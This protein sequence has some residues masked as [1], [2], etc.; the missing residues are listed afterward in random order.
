MIGKLFLPLLASHAA[1]AAAQPAS[2]PQ[3]CAPVPAEQLSI[4]GEISDAVRTDDRERIVALT[5]RLYGAGDAA[6]SAR[7]TA[8]IALLRW[9]S[10]SAGL[11]ALGSCLEKDRGAFRYKNDL[12]Q[13]VD[14]LRLQLLDGQ[15]PRVRVVKAVASVGERSRES[16][17]NP[18]QELDNYLAA[19]ARN[20]L[21]TGVVM[22][23]RNGQMVYSRATGFAHRETRQPITLHTLFNV[24]S[25][26]KIFTAVAI[27]QLVEAGKLSLSS[28]LKELLPTEVEGT[29]AES[30][31]VEHLLSH[32]SGLVNG[33]KTLGFAPGSSFSY[34][35]M[36]YRVLGEIIE[37]VSH[38]KYEDYVRLHITGPAGMSHTDIY[39]ASAPVAELAM[40]YMPSLSGVELRWVANPL[41]QT[42]PGNSIGGYWSNGPDLLRFAE[43]LKRGKLLKP[44]TVELMRRTKP[45]LGAMEYGFGV[46]RWRGPGIWGHGG[47][48]PGTNVDLEMHCDDGVVVVALSNHDGANPPVLAKARE[49]FFKGT[50]DI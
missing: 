11:V 24:A 35:N 12:T 48:L 43:A 30:I 15:P 9:S 31:Q 38:L 10:E 34:S 4:A 13:V 44:A 25:T 19:L 5:N 42:W 6:R 40:G 33:Y 7:E 28:T 16:N 39:Q 23:S 37:A 32:T 50:C 14:E 47:D 45:E 46:I 36:G 27:L 18:A 17:L 29:A 1:L 41:L 21:F 22:V 20:G 26:N 49:L 8:L 2:T 3:E